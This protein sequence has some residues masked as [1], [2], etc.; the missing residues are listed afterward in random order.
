MNPK[1]EPSDQ[2][3]VPPICKATNLPAL[4][5]REQVEAYHKANKLNGLFR[6]WKCPDCG[7]LHSK[8]TTT[9]EI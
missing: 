5:N 3:G 6:V 4:A 8:P 7:W 1:L 9:E 2:P